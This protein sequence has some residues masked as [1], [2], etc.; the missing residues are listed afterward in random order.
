MLYSPFNEELSHVI[1][2]ADE[3]AFVPADEGFFFPSDVKVARV[4][5]IML[6]VAF[7]SRLCC[8][9]CRQAGTC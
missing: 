4:T 7:I 5:N 2:I 9:S 8:N 6:Q 1:T 3:D